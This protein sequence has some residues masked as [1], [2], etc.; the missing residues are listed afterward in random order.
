MKDF[1]VPGSLVLLPNR[2]TP[3]ACRPAR[4]GLEVLV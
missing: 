1:T 3:S 2:V 4:D